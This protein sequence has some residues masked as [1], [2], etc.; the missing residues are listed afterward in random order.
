MFDGQALSS[1]GS[2]IA[3]SLYE[4]FGHV[5]SKELKRLNTAPEETPVDALRRT[6]LSINKDLAT[7]VTQDTDERLLLSHRGSA[8]SVALSQ[9]DLHSGGVATVIFLQESEL[10][11]ANV[12]D[13]QAVLIHLKAAIES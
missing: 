9:A 2:K 1:G 11:V 5:F 4:N 12:G 13:T 7:A 10:Y 6:F 3:K 8:A